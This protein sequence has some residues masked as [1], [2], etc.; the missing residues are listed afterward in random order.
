MTGVLAIIAGA[1]A[2]VILGGV[3]GLGVRFAVMF[4]WG[5]RPTP[6]ECPTLSICFPDVPTWGNVLAWLT[7][8]AV[9]TATIFVAW[10]LSSG[11]DR[12]SA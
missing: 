5:Q 11:T 6:Q 4:L 8:F 9:L 7:F 10:K 1:V 12:E 2:G 3:S